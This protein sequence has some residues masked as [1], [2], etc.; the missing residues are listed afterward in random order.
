MRSDT[1]VKKMQWLM[2]S[3]N[4]GTINTC[5]ENTSLHCHESYYSDSLPKGSKGD[6]KSIDIPAKLARLELS[7]QIPLKSPCEMRCDVVKACVRNRVSSDVNA[8]KK[9]NESG[10]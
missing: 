5:G 4:H 3:G 2:T 8:H 7:C 9:L 1:D 10:Y 6:A